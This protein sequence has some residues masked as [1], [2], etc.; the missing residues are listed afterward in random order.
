MP[1]LPAFY[2]RERTAALSVADDTTF[3]AWLVEE[4]GRTIGEFAAAE[5]TN[6]P[7]GPPPPLPVGRSAQSAQSARP[8]P[9][10]HRVPTS[11]NS[12]ADGRPV[13]PPLRDVR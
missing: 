6:A 10:L 7:E 5:W 11:S 8:A 4:S 1:K 13:P 12:Y 3:E 9:P 2:E